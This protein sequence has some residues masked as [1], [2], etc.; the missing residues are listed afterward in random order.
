MKKLIFGLLSLLLIAGTLTGQDAKKSF[1]DAK[2]SLGSYNL[3]PSGNKEKLNEAKVAIDEAITDGEISRDPD[4]W[5]LKGEIYNEVANQY[6]ILRQLPEAGDASSLPKAE[7]PAIE[8]SLAFQKAYELAEKRYQTRDA[9]K[10]MRT[11]QNNLNNMG[12]YHYEDQEYAEAHQNF[13]Q[14]LE[15]HKILK[16]EGEASSLDAVEDYNQQLYTTG[17]TAF[18]AG[19]MDAAEPFFKELYDINY[20][21]PSIY[22]VLYKINAGKSGPEE[23]FAYLVKGRE[24]YP[25]DIGLLFAEINHYLSINKLDALIEKLKAA[26]DKEPENVSLYN[27]TGSVFDQ[28]YQKEAKEGNEEKALGYFNQSLEYFKKALEVAPNNFDALYSIG[29]LYYNRA[30]LL[31]QGLQELADDYSKDGIAKY[32]ALREKIFA[33]FDKALP[34]FK[35]CEKINPNDVNTL[36][37]LKEIYAKKGE[38]EMSTEFKTRLENIQDGGT[39][40]S[41]FKANE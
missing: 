37:A 27:T 35:N 11:T 20:D 14:T 40:E 36:I 29:A 30:A 7:D 16:K 28:L 2:R 39:N 25:D 12:F 34:Y 32:E 24:A 33:E 41:Y 26:I 38:L 5:V 3:D 6:V 9:L 10:G 22:E 31:T 19:M 15:L 17:L 1:R 18:T 8:A 21:N 13:K 4:A 23:A